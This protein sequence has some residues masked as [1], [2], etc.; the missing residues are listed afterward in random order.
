MLGGVGFLGVLWLGD[1]AKVP[2]Q[3]QQVHLEPVFGHLAVHH[4]VDLDAREG[5]FFA[6]RWDALK[7]ATVGAPQ[8]HTRRDHVFCREDVLHREPKVGERLHK[9]GGEL[10]PGLQVKG[11]WESR[12]MGDVAW[13]QDVHFG[14]RPVGVVE[15][16][17]PPSNDR[18]VLLHF[19]HLSPLRA[20]A[21]SESTS[22]AEEHD[23]TTLSPA[24]TSESYPFHALW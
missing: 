14:L 1:G 12:T 10:L 16:F 17:D 3:T 18:L 9:G 19:R 23:A 6:G 2:H 13:S 24:R 20:P 15:R 22:A 7:L 5:H 8:C 21:L 4:A 11:A